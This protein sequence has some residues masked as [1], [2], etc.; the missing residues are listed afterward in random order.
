[1]SPTWLALWWRRWRKRGGGE[2]EKEPEGSAGLIELR[3]PGGLLWDGFV[4]LYQRTFPAWEREPLA[5]IGARVASGRYRLVVLQSQDDAVV[6]FH[7]VDV[8]PALDYAVLTFVAVSEEHRAGGL[9]RRLIEDAVERF[10]GAAAP[11]R[12][13]VEAEERPA[14][15]YQRCG[16]RRLALDYGVPHYDRDDGVQPMSLLVAGRA[17]TVPSVDGGLVRAVVE[18]L[19]RDGYQLGADDPRLAAQLAR[20][21]ARVGVLRC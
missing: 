9:G 2:G 10:R 3:S 15:L 13:F 4:Q 16:F 19:F 14:R 18:H 6:G 1:M 20:I 8:V 12:L 7:L 5:R 21:P 11:S 17:G